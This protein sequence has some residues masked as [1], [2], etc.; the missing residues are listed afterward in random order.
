MYRWRLGVWLPLAVLVAVLAHGVR[1][2]AQH[3]P[4]GA[5]AASLFGTLGAGL[6]LAAL[7]A[8]YLAAL[9]PGE[10]VARRR[11][12]PALPA[13]LTLGGLGAYGL[14]ELSEGRAP[15]A[16][17]PSVLL[18]VILAAALVSGLFHLIA[19]MLAASG[20]ALA[21]LTAGTK[22]R[23]VPPALGRETCRILLRCRLAA[24]HARG[25]APPLLS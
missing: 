23:G 17:G 14:I 25:R 6:A 4:A 24:G 13:P 16:G 22:I 12:P 1:F 3:L 2:G 8:V 20:R 9:R 15:F 5:H 19:G 10:G 21:A 11:C 18:T 7:T